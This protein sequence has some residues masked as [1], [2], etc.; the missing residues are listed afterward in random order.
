L[1]NVDNMLPHGTGKG[2]VTI[3]AAGRLELNKN[4]GGTQTINGLNGLAGA[5]VYNNDNVPAS[6]TNFV[7]G[8]G[9]A[10][11]SYAGTITNRPDFASVLSVQKIG[12]GT[13]VFSGNSDYSGTTA[14]TAG[15][16]IVDGNHSGLAEYTV[17]ANGLLGG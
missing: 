5:Q 11:G 13:Q 14:V 1:A 8:D 7:L 15:S 16:L 10:N 12:A 4:G 3:G 6:V 9:D 17:A 2:N